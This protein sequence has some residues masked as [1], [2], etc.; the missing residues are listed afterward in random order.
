MLSLSSYLLLLFSPPIYAVADSAAD[1]A[2]DSP[3]SPNGLNISSD[4]TNH[5][6]QETQVNRH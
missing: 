3:T 5:G 2:A 6:S 1:S 4:T